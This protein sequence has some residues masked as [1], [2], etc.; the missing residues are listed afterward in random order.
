M[1]D[2]PASPTAFVPRCAAID[3]GIDAGLDPL[4]SAT[5][6]RCPSGSRTTHA[7]ALGAITAS[8]PITIMAAPRRKL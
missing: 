6:T 4:V 7:D 1:L 5:L 3:P 8:A 2:A